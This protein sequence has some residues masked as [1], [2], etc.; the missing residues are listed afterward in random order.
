MN[1]IDDICTCMTIYDIYMIDDI[2]ML[3]YNNQPFIFSETC[4]KLGLV[5]CTA[6]IQCTSTRL[7]YARG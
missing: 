7:A 5:L 2:Y 4:I 3:E 6:N 1:M